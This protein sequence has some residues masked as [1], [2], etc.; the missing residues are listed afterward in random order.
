[1]NG[2]FECS[3][4]CPI[5]DESRDSGSNHRDVMLQQKIDELRHFETEV[6]NLRPL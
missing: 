6:N 5:P 4:S 1:M 3:N 2:D